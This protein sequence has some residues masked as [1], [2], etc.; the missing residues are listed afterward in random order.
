MKK[1]KGKKGFYSVKT[2]S[3]DGNTLKYFR[4]FDHKKVDYWLRNEIK[5]SINSNN[6]IAIF[7][8]KNYE[9]IVFKGNLP[10]L[11]KI[12]KLLNKTCITKDIIH[13]LTN[14]NILHSRVK[15]KVISYERDFYSKYLNLYQLAFI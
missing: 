12:G 14:N 3:I 6:E 13:I 10:L 5:A 9:F 11:M 2:E 8:S 1:V 7:N 15:Y 4:F